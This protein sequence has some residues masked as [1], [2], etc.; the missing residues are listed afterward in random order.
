[1][2]QSDALMVCCM[3]VG[4]EATAMGRGDVGRA[5]MRLLPS[6]AVTSESP[7]TCAAWRRP[8]NRTIRSEPINRRGKAP[9]GEMKEGLTVG[10]RRRRGDGRRRCA[11]R[12]RRRCNV[13]GES[14]GGM[15]F[16]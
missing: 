10:V 3:C 13:D 2:T 4:R 16:V 1:M 14:S 12:G 7:R 9:S 8:K 15:T 11:V 6:F 5:D